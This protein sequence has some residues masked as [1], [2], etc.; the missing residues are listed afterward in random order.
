M[1]VSQIRRA[2]KRITSRYKQ[3][4]ISIADS[5][6]RERKKAEKQAATKKRKR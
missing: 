5:M 1:T 3:R 2:R 6:A 4:T